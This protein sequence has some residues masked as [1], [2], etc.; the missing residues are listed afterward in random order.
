MI[1]HVSSYT[2][3]FPKS[4]AFYETVM[5]SLGY[6]VH[7]EMVMTWDEELPN[8]RACAW[9]PG[10]AVFWLIEVKEAYTPR[11]L[12]FS[13][14]DRASVDGFHAAALAAGGDGSR[15]AGPAADLS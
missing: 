13:A 4:R 14:P 8:R 12:A 1:D 2:L 11:H 10:R 6:A 9:G 15:R 3:D 7:A 5:Q